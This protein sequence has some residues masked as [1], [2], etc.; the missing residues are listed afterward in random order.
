LLEF[1]VR[2]DLS[3]FRLGGKDAGSGFFVGFGNLR[4]AAD[5]FLVADG[6]GG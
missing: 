1:S 3:R 6:M 5:E 2:D 4:E